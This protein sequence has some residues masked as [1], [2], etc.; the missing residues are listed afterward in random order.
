MEQVITPVIYNPT[1]KV[2]FEGVN[3]IYHMNASDTYIPLFFFFSLFFKF[4]CQQ[5]FIKFTLPV[6]SL[7]FVQLSL[8]IM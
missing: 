6:R 4:S 5:T 2:Y 7:L 8:A 1:V 3:I